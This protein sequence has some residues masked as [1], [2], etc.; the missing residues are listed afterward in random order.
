MEI[1]KN[2]SGKKVLVTGAGGFIGSHLVERLVS[3][4]ADVRAFVHYNSRND[5][6]LLDDLSDWV[7]ESLEIVRGDVQD[8][9]FVAKVV[10]GC[11]TVFHLASLIPIPYSYVAPQSFVATNV[12]GAVNVMQACVTESVE[13]VV[14]TSTSEAYGTAQYVPIDEKHPLRGQSPYSASKIGADMIAESYWRSFALPVA[15][16]RPFNTYGPRQ[17]ARAVIPTII[18]QALSGDVIK[19]GSTETTRDL[20]YV[21][22]TVEGFLRVAAT[23]AAVGQ[24]TNIGS[25]QEISIG[26]LAETILQ[27][28]QIASRIETDDQRLRPVASEVERLRCDNSKAKTLLGWESKVSLEDGLQ[29]TIDWMRQN[30]DRYKPQLYYV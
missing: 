9:F 27:L 25:G 23:P 22:D 17:S 16:I 19:L 2:L 12:L 13:C 15:T 10:R 14:H 18:M 28:L 4:G 1:M 3:E 5:C 26:K 6:G 29:R 20:S 30:V 8:P 24:V 21:D 11:N 7:R